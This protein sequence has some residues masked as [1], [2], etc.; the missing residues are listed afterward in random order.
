MEVDIFSD[1]L[2]NGNEAGRDMNVDPTELLES[3]ADTP[4]Q[5]LLDAS[6]A[7]SSTM[8]TSSD[9]AHQRQRPCTSQEMQGRF[10]FQ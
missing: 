6:R 2:V 10:A 1:D 5:Q 4:E 9:V 8:P 7:P 3:V